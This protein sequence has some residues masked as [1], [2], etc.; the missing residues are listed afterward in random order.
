M[1]NV[2]NPVGSWW[3]DRLASNFGCAVSSGGGSGLVLCVGSMGVGLGSTWGTGR[4][5]R[6]VLPLESAGMV[7]F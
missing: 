6:S 3:R 4:I 1:N 7:E 2:S 5:F